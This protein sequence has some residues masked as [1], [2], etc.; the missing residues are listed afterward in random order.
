[1][2]FS[3]SPYSIICIDTPANAALGCSQQVPYWLWGV[4]L[5]SFKTSICRGDP[6]RAGR[7]FLFVSGEVVGFS[8]A[9][10]S[11]YFSLGGICK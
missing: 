6:R 4:P 3:A 7:I 8:G 2:I 5:V 11:C 10:G 9:T 1:M